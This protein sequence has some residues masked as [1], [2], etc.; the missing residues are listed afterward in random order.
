LDD[1][2]NVAVIDSVREKVKA[3]CAKFPVYT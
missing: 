1:I 3:L 2:D